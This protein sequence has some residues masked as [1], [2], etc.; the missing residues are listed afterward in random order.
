MDPGENPL[1]GVKR[2]MLEE[3]RYHGHADFHHLY[4]FRHSSGFIYHNYLAV[5]DAEFTPHLDWENSGFRWVPFGKWPRPLHPGAAL[6]IKQKVDLLKT[7]V[8]DM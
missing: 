8:G 4:D 6:L 7:L 1:Q 3:T 5:V 2:E